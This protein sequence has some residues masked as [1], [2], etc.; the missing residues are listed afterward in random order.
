MACLMNR[1]SDS[2]SA[3]YL[4]HTQQQMDV[5]KMLLTQLS[6]AESFK[7]TSTCLTQNMI[8]L[9]WQSG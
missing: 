2:L 1:K 3:T 6:S 8:T 4:L 7:N 9:P 5:W